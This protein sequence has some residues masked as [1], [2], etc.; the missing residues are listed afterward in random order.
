MK[1]SLSFV[2]V[3]IIATLS[4]SGLA[5]IGTA[6]ASGPPSSVAG[7]GPV[8][9]GGT[10]GTPVTSGSTWTLYSL[11][12][13]TH[14]WCFVD[15]FG[16]KTFS[17]DQGGGGTYKSTTKKTK[18]VDTNSTVLNTT[19]NYSSTWITGDTTYWNGT[20]SA[21]GFVYGPIILVQGDNPLGWDD[22]SNG[23]PSC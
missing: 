6:G 11:E 1:R 15:T 8:P 23:N 19:F 14:Y 17:D 13:G 2:A 12:F 9:N 7:G 3:G 18:M 22:A 10:I 5:C 21:G 4:L 16:T 20:F